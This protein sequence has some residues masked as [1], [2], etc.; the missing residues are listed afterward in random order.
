MNSWPKYF[1]D[2]KLNDDNCKEIR[3]GVFLCK[4]QAG[5]RKALKYDFRDF[6]T[7]AE[8]KK[9]IHNYPKKYPCI[10][11]FSHGESDLLGIQVFVAY[12]DDFKEL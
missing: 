8:L 6:E 1:I 2:M 12:E 4:T 7:F 10:V 3:L 5:F 11:E 9:M